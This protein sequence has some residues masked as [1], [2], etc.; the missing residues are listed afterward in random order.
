MTDDPHPLCQRPDPDPPP[1]KFSVPAG[2]ID[3]HAHIFGTEPEY[4]FSPSRGYTPP[5]VSL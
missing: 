1:A 3:C 5:E 2:T 4:P